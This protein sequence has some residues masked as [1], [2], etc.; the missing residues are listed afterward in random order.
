M[1]LPANVSYGKV[2]GRY[3]LAVGD[4][5]DAGSDPDSVSAVGTATFT[6]SAAVLNDTTSTPPTSILP[7]SVVCAF[8]ANGDIIDSEGNV[9]VWLLATDDPDIS[10]LNW[11]WRVV[12]SFAGI[13][14]PISFSF[15]LPSD[16]TVDLTLVTPL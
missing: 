3:I 7:Q 16:E 6:P 13:A 1:P 5:G 14:S 11:T 9:G 12:L 10:P 15:S 2:I 4:G 8:D